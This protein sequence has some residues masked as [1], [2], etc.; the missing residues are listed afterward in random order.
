[1]KPNSFILLRENTVKSTS[2]RTEKKKKLQCLSLT[3]DADFEN[4]IRRR[5]EF[6]QA[7]EIE[8]HRRVA[9]LSMMGVRVRQRRRASRDFG[10][11]R[12]LDHQ[13]KG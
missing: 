5:Y 7:L 8:K 13:Q 12:D 4:E 2:P 11:G 1:L 3:G 9:A 10:E 6:D